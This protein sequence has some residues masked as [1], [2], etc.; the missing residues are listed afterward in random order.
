VCERFTNGDYTDRESRT[1]TVDTKPDVS[2]SVI[3]D[4]NGNDTLTVTYDFPSTSSYTDRSIKL[5]IDGV[6][7]PEVRPNAV[8]GSYPVNLGSTCWLEARA[9]ATACGRTGDPASTDVDVLPAT[10]QTPEITGFGLRRLGI[11]PGSNPAVRK[12]ELRFGY[13]LRRL[14][15]GSKVRVEVLS[16]R[17]ADGQ[18]RPGYLLTEYTSPVSN[19]VVLEFPAPSGAQQVGVLVTAQSCGTATAQGWVD[20]MAC[21]GGATGDPVYFSDGNMLLTDTDPLPPVAGHTL[22]RTY[23][24]DEQVVSLFGRGFTTLFDRRLV[25]HDVA[26]RQFVS[27]STETGEVVTFES[28][29]GTFRQTWP[30]SRRTPGVLKHDAAA[31]TYSYRAAGSEEAAVFDAANGRLVALRELGT[32]REARIAYDAAGLPQTFTDSWTAV[33]WIFTIVQRR[34]TSIAV[35]DRPDLTWSYQYDAAGNLTSLFAPSAAVW[36]TYE[37]AANRMTASRDA[38]GNL[39]E[40][41]AYNNDGYATDSTGPTDEIASIVYD[42]P[43]TTASE[44]I[45]RV[46]MKTGAV[47]DY[48]MR[49]SGGAYRTVEVSGSCTTCGGGSGDRTYVRDASGRV[50]RQQ[51]ADGYVTVTSYAG[52]RVASE[53]RFLKPSACDPESDT[54][55]CRMT[56]DELAAATLAPTTSTIKTEY[57]YGDNNWPERPTAILTPSVGAPATWRRQDI[58]YHPVSGAATTTTV[59]GFTGPGAWMARTTTTTFYEAPSGLEVAFEPGGSFAAAWLS[60]PQPARAVKSING[61]RLGVADETSFVYYP[62][63][64]TVPSLLRGRLAATKNAAGHVTRF[65]SYDVFGNVTRV[66]DPNGVVRE[67]TSDILGRPATS[68]VKAVSGC[69]TTAD[70]LCAT[71]LVT[72]RTYS[73]AAGPLSREERAGGGV[74]VYTYDSRG[75]IRT[76]SRGPSVASLRE[77]IEYSYDPLTGKKSLERILGLQN[78]TW[79]EKKHESYE[80]NSLRELIAVT[81]AD[82]T[83]VGYTYDIDGRIA[84]LRDETHAAA[85]TIY[86]YD[87]AGR[88]TSVAQTLAGAP[89]GR[90]TTRY[91]YDA[92]GNL[93]SVTDPNGNVT[94]YVYSDFGVMIRQDSPVTGTTTYE[95][96]A[97]ENLTV[98]T[99]ANGAKTT[100]QYDALNRITRAEA[101][102]NGASEVVVWRYD[103]TATGRFG[104]GRIAAM[105]DPAGSTEYHYERRGLLRMEERSF[106]A[107]PSTT[108]THAATTKFK[109][110][111]DGNR[112]SITYPSALVVD[113]TFDFAGRPVTA[114]GFVTSAAYLPF[115]PLTELRLANGTT[116]TIEYDNRYRLTANELTR[117]VAPSTPLVRYVYTYDGSGNVLGIQDALDSQYSRYFAYDD[118]HRLITANTGPSPD[119]QRSQGTALWGKGSYTWDAMGNLLTMKLGEIVQEPDDQLLR[120]PWTPR[121]E[122]NVPRGRSTTFTYA[123]TTPRV[124]AV[125]T[126]DIERSV[127]YDAAGNEISHVVPRTYSPRNLLATVV[128]SNDTEGNAPHTL[129]YAYDGRGIRVMRAE[130]PSSGPNT[131]ARRYYVYSP[132]LRLLSVT[133]DDGPN[134]WTGYSGCSEVFG[135]CIATPNNVAYEIVW[136]GD[137]PVGQ[138][139]P[140]SS[141]TKT[142][143]FTDHLGTPILETDRY[144]TTIIWRAEHEPFGNI[145]AMRQDAN[146]DDIGHR[147]DNPLRFPGQEAAMN[148]EGEEENYNVFRWYRAGWGRY[149]QADPITYRPTSFPFAEF[150]LDDLARAWDSDFDADSNEAFG[151]AQANPVRST[152]P[153]GLLTQKQSAC[154]ATY[155]GAGALGGAIAGASGGLV[156][157]AGVLSAPGAVAGAVIGGLGGAIVGTL[158]CT[159]VVSEIG[160]CITEFARTRTWK[161]RARCSLYTVPG[162]MGA[163]YIEGQG[164][165]SNQNEACKAAKKNASSS[166]PA[167]YRTK[168]CQCY[169]SNQ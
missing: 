149:T 95:Y 15:T 85:N 150:G 83:G 17:D 124:S 49:P 54:D 31:G 110:D 109:Y 70:P 121:T 69:D 6:E 106:T 92:H 114:S 128:D 68:T 169:C 127:A 134:I 48:I 158:V 33:T 152:D 136:F 108:P 51:S 23:N 137:R 107:P 98:S 77:Q 75:R 89:G 101:V 133:R 81:H 64:P 143:T 164:S 139:I 96:D 102:L 84:T 20:C 29:N 165:G 142:H 135:D 93:Q 58:S 123:G 132:E 141:R 62:V 140:S 4:A 24:S 167:G 13:D 42:L 94:S 67:T 26:G 145:Y 162:D 79:V 90:I 157:T 45:T 60:L 61:P 25:G 34:V 36:R 28:V 155:A 43:G 53:E 10:H 87:P 111:R 59:S 91:T 55:H 112:T 3:E 104:M 72:S 82:G 118:L 146:G 117:D 129:A 21:D 30:L 7:Q 2:L 18:T 78:G 86:E 16:W 47:T 153:L 144:G 122:Q 115:G 65:E 160:G 159:D 113:Y 38:L 12:I 73:P 19:D 138:S 163:G 151:Y 50:I 71:D 46:T 147:L 52:D 57:L 161:C 99:D 100:R 126:N 14:A 11:V 37:Y 131:T 27:V 103:D 120:V 35:G 168:H 130:S 63:D 39:I 154:I 9:V 116:Q 156:T 56:T 166:A 74:S 76:I 80:Y 44:R 66:V 97:G 125:I 22:T 5:S 40:S 41:H 88:V 8:S 105:T 32:G 1:I 148:W 119:P